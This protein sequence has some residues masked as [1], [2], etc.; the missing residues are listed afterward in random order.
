MDLLGM[1]QAEGLDF[2][3][4]RNNLSRQ[5]MSQFNAMNREYN[6]SSGGRGVVDSSLG[7]GGESATARYQGG[8]VAL[9][10]GAR[11]IIS[12]ARRGDSFVNGSG[13]IIAN[14]STALTGGRIFR[15]YRYRANTASDRAHKKYAGSKLIVQKAISMGIKSNPEWADRIAE[16]PTIDHK[17]EDGIEQAE[18]AAL[19]AESLAT[20]YVASINSQMTSIGFTSALTSASNTAGFSGIGMYENIALLSATRRSNFSNTEIVEESRNKLNLTNSQ[21]YAIRFNSTRGDVELQDRLRYV[22]Q[23]DA[24]SSGTSPL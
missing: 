3:K 24:M 7:A 22:D 23:L 2:T 5:S 9:N 19:A 21:V 20:Q 14:I 12:A 1:R 17:E 18:F 4:T 15:N 6:I 10:E 11:N 8:S 13:G 16:I